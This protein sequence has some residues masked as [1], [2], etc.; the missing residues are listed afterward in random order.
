M[1]EIARQLTKNHSNRTRIGWRACTLRLLS[2]TRRVAQLAMG[3]WLVRHRDWVFT[4]I[5]AVWT[6]KVRTRVSWMTL[7]LK[8]IA[9]KIQAMKVKMKE[10]I[11][12]RRVRVPPE[13]WPRR[14][15]AYPTCGRRMKPGITMATS[16]SVQTLVTMENRYRYRSFQIQSCLQDW[17]GKHKCF[18]VSQLLIGHVH[19]S[20]PVSRMAQEWSFREVRATSC[21]FKTRI[22][23]RSS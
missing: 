5:K 6:A 14:A 20:H 7:P 15:Q 13:I 11:N 10:Q 23:A 3:A 17:D 9:N 22:L 16:F 2:S 4:R 12:L 8:I 1:C 21:M 19:L 18:A